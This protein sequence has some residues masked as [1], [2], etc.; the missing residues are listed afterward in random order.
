MTCDSTLQL[1]GR[2]RLLGPLIA[3]EARQTDAQQFHKAKE[4]L[5]SRAARP[6]V[7]PDSTT[8]P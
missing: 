1:V 7:R 5:E 8:A 6:H 2:Y 3:R 4:I